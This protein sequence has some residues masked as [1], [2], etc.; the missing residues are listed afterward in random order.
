MIRTSHVRMFL[1]ATSFALVAACGSAGTDGAP[2]TGDDQ[3]VTA[4]NAAKPKCVFGKTFA[5]G[6]SKIGK[7]KAS[8][9]TLAL[10]FNKL[11]TSR[12]VAALHVSSHTEVTTVA[13]ALAAADD[14]EIDRYT[15]TDKKQQRSFEAY[16]Y[17]A[18]DNTFGAIF[19]GTS[20]QPVAR[21][22]DSAITSCTIKN[23]A[24][25]CL[26]GKNFGGGST[27]GGT[28]A[29]S[30]QLG[31]VGAAMEKS[32]IVAALHVSSHTEVT[33]AEEA[34]AAA[35]QGVIDRYL[36]VDETTQKEYQ[37]FIYGA[38]DNAFGA[39]FEKGTT[40]QV[41]SIEDSAITSCTVLR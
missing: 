17:G 33:S 5:E 28:R 9:E 38:G 4:K 39:I 2:A 20:A 30:I 16:I 26:F 31:S 23:A 6:S 22:E 12:I 29:S 14:K 11:D 34:F 36:L 37:A 41:A 21:I 27:I 10:T 19:A 15:L 1:T 18:G 8:F 32:Q 40:T 3:N 25:N 13:Q 7:T 24:G 35:D